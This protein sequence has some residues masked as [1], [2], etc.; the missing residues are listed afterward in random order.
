MPVITLDNWPCSY[1]HEGA[2]DRPPLLLSHSLGLDLSMW[3]PQAVDLSRHFQVVRFDTRGH[4]AS[5]VTPGDYT[6]EQL[7]HDALGLADA[8]HL[9]RFA[10]CGLSLGGMIGMWIAEHAPERLTHLVLANTSP[11]PDAPTMESRRTTVLDRG[12]AAIETVVMGRFFSAASLQANPPAVS[13]AR[14]TLLATNPIG[15]AGCCAAIRDHDA[16]AALPHIRIPTLVISGDGDVSLPWTGH[17]EIL[18]GE[19]PG[20][21]V[22]HLPTAHISNLERPR[23]FSAALF[24]FLLAGPG[25]SL[26][27]GAAVRRATLGEAHV[28]RATR[29]GTEFTRDFQDYLTR[30]VWGTIWTRPGLDRR[31]RRLLVLTTTAALGRWEEYRLHVR[32]ALTS[33]VEPCDL[34]ETLLQ[35]A[36]YAGVPCANTAFHIAQEELSRLTAPPPPGTA[37]ERL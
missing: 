30:T 10:F 8:L 33:D 16:R 13:W 5:G 17:S 18:A 26:E 25:D 21:R 1:R 34:K 29:A 24:D 6:I 27:A 11:R 4:G 37:G 35:I 28:D 36:G 14:R 20:A 23:S 31:T 2:A 19:I 12:M 22:V 7:G 9:P 3:E 32:A 15:Y